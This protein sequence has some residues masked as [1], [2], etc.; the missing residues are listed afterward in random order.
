MSVGNGEPVGRD[1]SLGKRLAFVG[2]IYLLR[3]VRV[4]PV[5][6]EVRTSETSVTERK[7]ALTSQASVK[8][9]NGKY[10]KYPTCTRAVS[11]HLESDT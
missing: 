4:V 2:N 1:I 7:G 9:T 6:A 10:L 5:V 11:E 3:P 8:Q